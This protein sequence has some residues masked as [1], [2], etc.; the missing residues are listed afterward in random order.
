MRIQNALL[1]TQHISYE[2]K[3]KK[4]TAYDH[5]KTSNLSADNFKK[6]VDLDGLRP[7]PAIRTGDTGQQI[8]FFVN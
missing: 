1:L 7:E 4:L 5:L 6:M 3:K 2:L 8:P